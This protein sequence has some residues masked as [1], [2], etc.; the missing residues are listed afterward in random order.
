[1]HAI[2][3][4]MDDLDAEASRRIGEALRRLPGVRDVKVDERQNAVRVS[5]SPDAADD[6][7]DKQR[8]IDA[9]E[10]AGGAVERIEMSTD[11]PSP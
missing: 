4:L 1:M 8:L 10:D 11:A 5:L 7:R 2:M 9:V 3:L 6:E